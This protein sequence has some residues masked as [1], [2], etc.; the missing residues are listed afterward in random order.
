MPQFHLR[1]ALVPGMAAGVVWGLSDLC[2]VFA[3]PF[4]GYAVAYP[5]LQCALLVSGEWV[6]E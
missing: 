2:A 3:I 1:T 5:I 6:G 4:L